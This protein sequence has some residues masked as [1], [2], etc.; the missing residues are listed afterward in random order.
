MDAEPY[1]ELSRYWGDLAQECNQIGAQFRWLNAFVFRQQGADGLACIG[2]FGP[3]Q[4]S[5]NRRFEIEA[6]DFWHR[7]K[8]RAGRSDLSWAVIR[9]GIF[10][11]QNEQV[12]GGEI[13]DV[14][15]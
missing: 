14:E 8:A 9:L 5:D 11:S 6:A 3:G 15:A 10:S 2:A 7:V 13:G 1:S 4:S 12:V